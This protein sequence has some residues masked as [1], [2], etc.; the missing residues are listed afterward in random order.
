M[1]QIQNMV[2]IGELPRISTIDICTMFLNLMHLLIK[3]KSV[4]KMCVCGREF[5]TI[6]VH[7]L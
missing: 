6:Y 7:R 3:M 5:Q 1:Y 2:K 4:V